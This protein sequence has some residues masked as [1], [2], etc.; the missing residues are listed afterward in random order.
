MAVAEIIITPLG[1]ASPSLSKYVAKVHKVLERY[2]VK[3]QL[4]PMST[5]IEADTDTI[6]KIAKEMHEVL[7]EEGIQR[8]VTNLRIDERRDK[9]LTMEGKVKAVMEKLKGE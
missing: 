4:T 2:K 8:V 9:E 6:F 5:I 3:Y 1:T 7:F